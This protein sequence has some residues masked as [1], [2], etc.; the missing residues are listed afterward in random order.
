MCY[1]GTNS[2]NGIVKRK[3]IS[4]ILGSDGYVFVYRDSEKIPIMEGINQSYISMKYI[5]LMGKMGS[6]N[7]STEFYLDC[8]K[9][10]EDAAPTTSIGNNALSSLNPVLN[11]I[12]NS[13]RPLFSNQQ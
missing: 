7:S 10:K 12:Y 3:L 13:I 8:G 11:F 4:N 5:T 6:E 9:A 2:L 1:C